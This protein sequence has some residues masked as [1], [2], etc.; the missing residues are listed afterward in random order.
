MGFQFLST[1]TNYTPTVST[2]LTGGTGHTQVQMQRDSA[3]RVSMIGL[4]YANGSPTDGK[5][6]TLAWDMFPWP[7]IRVCTVGDCNNQR[8][9][10]DVYAQNPYEYFVAQDQ[11]A[12]AVASGVFCGLNGVWQTAVPSCWVD[13]G[14][15]VV[16]LI[17]EPNVT[18]SPVGVFQVS[19][20][21]VS[22]VVKGQPMSLY[23][24][25]Q[26]FSMPVTVG[27]GQNGYGFIWID[28]VNQ[29]LGGAA[30]TYPTSMIGNPPEP[31]WN[32]NTWMALAE[33]GK[34][35]IWEFLPDYTSGYYSTDPTRNWD[36]RWFAR[37]PMDWGRVGDRLPG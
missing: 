10:F 32:P 18:I 5:I 1:W 15:Q 23:V 28:M 13:Y 12:V 20:G 11:T 3:G 16:G 22:G 2:G 6:C 17:R 9:R 8:S 27:G 30:Y 35:V 24:P 25:S 36:H 21:Q 29:A 37:D 7:N 19:S 33:E 4:A 34:V 14:L 31:H 26:T